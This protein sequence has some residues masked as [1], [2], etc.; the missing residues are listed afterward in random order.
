MRFVTTSPT[1]VGVVTWVL[2]A[3]AAAAEERAG[4]DSRFWMKALDAANDA[5]ALGGFREACMG[6]ADG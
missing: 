5:E 2:S 4:F 1:G 3:A 6:N